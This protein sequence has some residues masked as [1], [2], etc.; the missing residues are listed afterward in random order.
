MTDKEVVGTNHHVG[1]LI[2][3]LPP[4]CVTGRIRAMLKQDSKADFDQRH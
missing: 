1:T 3:L 2:I 4:S